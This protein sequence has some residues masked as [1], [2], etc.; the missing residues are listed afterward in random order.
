[1]GR[2]WILWWKLV[3]AIGETKFIYQW[4]PQK[5]YKGT[6]SPNVSICRLG[7]S[8]TFEQAS[9]RHSF[10]EADGALCRDQRVWHF[11]EVRLWPRIECGEVWRRRTTSLRSNINN[12]HK[13]RPLHRRLRSVCHLRSL[14][15]AS[16]RTPVEHHPLPNSR[17]LWPRSLQL[18]QRNKLL[19]WRYKSTAHS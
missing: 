3:W 7:F 18:R 8:R 15:V 19:I 2:T 9:A 14:L 16:R 5:C 1:M 10:H 4:W 11:Q 12:R 6:R 13:D 17:K